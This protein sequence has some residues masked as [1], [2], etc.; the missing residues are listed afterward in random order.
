MSKVAIAIG[1]VVVLGGVAYAGTELYLNREAEREVANFAA[2]ISDQADFSY[3]RVRTSLWNRNARVESIQITFPD[4]EQGLTI[5]QA[6]VES[7]DILNDPPTFGS[8]SLSGLR[9]D[10]DAETEEIAT[11]L[12]YGDLSSDLS[13]SYALSDRE[14]DFA[15]Q[16]RT[17]SAFG[18]SLDMQ[19]LD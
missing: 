10:L 3:R 15:M 18:F 9:F 17:A 19:L 16:W 1:A 8:V 11:A 12:D 13:L 7:W 5:E 2:S 4:I 14:V 6:E